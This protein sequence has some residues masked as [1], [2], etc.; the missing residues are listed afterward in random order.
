[1][2]NRE[3]ELYK[4]VYRGTAI[5]SG[6]YSNPQNKLPSNDIGM[7]NSNNLDTEIAVLKRGS[8]ARKGCGYNASLLAEVWLRMLSAFSSITPTLSAQGI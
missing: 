3:N 4:R 2:Q 5:T 1:M 8:A 7:I 6:T